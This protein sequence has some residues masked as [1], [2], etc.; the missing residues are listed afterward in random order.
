MNLPNWIPTTLKRC[1]PHFACWILVLA[2]QV[3]SAQSLEV[4]D[5]APSKPP[6]HLLSDTRDAGLTDRATAPLQWGYVSVRPHA[7]YRVTR[8][9]GILS[10]PGSTEKT[11]ISTVSPGLLFEVG[12]R[13]TADYT[14]SWIMYSD[15]AF[16]DAVE[17]A[18]EILGRALFTDGS[19]NFAQSYNLSNSPRVE[20]GLQTREETSGTS[21]N[22]NYGLTAKTRLEVAL[23]QRLR[24]VESAPNSRD[25]S[26]HGWFHYLVSE[27]LDAAAGVAVGYTAVDPGTDMFYTQPQVR[28]G[29]K[30]TGKLGVDAQF[31]LEQR[32]F[33][34]KGSADLNTP[35]YGI[36]AFY[37]PFQHTMVSLSGSRSVDVAYFVG[38][39]NENETVSLGLSQRLLQYF[40][41]NATAAKTNTQYIP[42]GATIITTV[43]DDTSYMYN[44]RLSTSFLRRGTI[45]IIYQR[46]RNSTNVAGYGFSSNQLGLEASYAY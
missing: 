18:L 46:T 4:S 45:G 37:Q 27:R 10:L 11:T 9:T 15:E 43:R 21:V 8:G 42:S 35:T 3:A 44:F 14:P 23:S 12:Q 26:T 1:T 25:W 34:R 7:L 22:V 33:R 16:E 20:T 32:R 39:V 2:T 24:W 30:P 5:P 29:W 13:W 41:F 36:T 38:Q 31:G 6:L 40:N 28:I 19:I 17:H